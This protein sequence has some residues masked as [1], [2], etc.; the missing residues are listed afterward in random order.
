MENSI[1]S[2]MWLK[3]KCFEVGISPNEFRKCQ[4]RDIKDI[5]ELKNAV[6]ERALREQKVREMMGTLK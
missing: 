4:I 5:M 1:E 2:M 6:D 3:Y